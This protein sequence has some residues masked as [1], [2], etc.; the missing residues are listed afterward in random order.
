MPTPRGFHDYRWKY[1]SRRDG[2]RWSVFCID[3]FEKIERRVVGPFWRWRTAERVAQE[4]T[5]HYRSGFDMG[6]KGDAVFAGGRYS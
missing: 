4:F 2:W 5:K 6:R 3:A 1:Y